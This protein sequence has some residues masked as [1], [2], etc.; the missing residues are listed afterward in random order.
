[1]NNKLFE[2]I[3]GNKFKMSFSEA[4]S[5]AT[6]KAN[7]RKAINN[8]IHKREELGGK[9]KVD[10]VGQA[11]NILAKVLDDVGYTLGMV[12]GDLILGDKGSRMLSFSRKSTNPD[13]QIEGQEITNSRISFNWEVTSHNL[14]S[15]TPIYGDKKYEIVA[16][17]S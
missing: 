8:A 4:I 13:P 11:I 17:A 1:M 3:G 14:N 2:N 10:S 5:E 16:Y 6:L 15:K 12:S 7:E 9:I